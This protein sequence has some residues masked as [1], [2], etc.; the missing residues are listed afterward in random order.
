M[1]NLSKLMQAVKMAQEGGGEGGQ[2]AGGFE[3]TSLIK[4]DLSGGEGGEGGESDEGSEGD[5]SEDGSSDEGGEGGEGADRPEWL[6][7]GFET[8]EQFAE[9]YQN[10]ANG[11]VEGVPE[12]GEYELNLA[13]GYENF[14]FFEHEQ[15]DIKSFMQIAKEENIPQ[16]A[17]DRIL[18]AYM[19]SRI[20]GEEIEIVNKHN[21]TLKFIGGEKELQ[22]INAKAKAALSPEDFKLLQHATSTAP[23]AAGAVIKL[24]KSLALKGESNPLNTPP[25][26]GGGLLSKDELRQMQA[27]PRYKTSAEFRQKVA[28][29]YK[30]LENSGQ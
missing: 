5:G 16:K 9:A 21:A 18:N 28:D 7:E 24:V 23:D 12:T 17:F 3:S 13:E 26:G 2:A 30:A 20:A 22:T 15:G 19:D 8:P 6:P 10:L 11:V 1:F 27:D 4:D 25:S 29:G 14:T